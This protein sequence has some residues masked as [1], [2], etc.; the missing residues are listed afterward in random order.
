[1]YLRF[2]PPEQ[3]EELI[4]LI[5]TH[6]IKNATHGCVEFKKSPEI[7]KDFGLRFLILFFCELVNAKPK[8]SSSDSE[9]TVTITRE[10]IKAHS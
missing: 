7:I 3:Q 8:S 6:N 5:E 9:K 1:M 2:L 10:Y 4:S